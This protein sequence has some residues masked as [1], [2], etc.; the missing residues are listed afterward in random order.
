MLRLSG[1]TVNCDEPDELAG[2][3]AQALG[4]HYRTLWEPYTGAKD[5]EHDD[6]NL[7]FQRSADQPQQNHLHLDLYSNEPN[8]DVERLL[9]LGATRV[10]HVEEG[11]TWWW[12]LRDP[13]GNEFCV[14]AAIGADRSV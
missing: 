14:I 6:P 3:W 10:R 2:F 1:I 12:V 5:P 11:D 7:T 13:A 4:Y 8:H 9:A